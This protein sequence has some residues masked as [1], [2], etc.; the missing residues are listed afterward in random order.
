MSSLSTFDSIVILFILSIIVYFLYFKKIS[1]VNDRESILTHLTNGRA[2]IGPSLKCLLALSDP[3]K[4]SYSERVA[5]A[6]SGSLLQILSRSIDSSQEF[7]TQG[8]HPNNFLLVVLII[9]K[10][11]IILDDVSQKILLLGMIIILF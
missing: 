7:L 8:R 4:S 10:N 5:L 1:T 6:N 3:S 11:L 2:E 9:L